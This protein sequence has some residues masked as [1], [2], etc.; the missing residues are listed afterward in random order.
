MPSVDVT[1]SWEQTV[2]RIMAEADKPIIENQT[3]EN[4]V[5][6]SGGLT[7]NLTVGSGQVEISRSSKR[8][9]KSHKSQSRP[10]RRRDRRRDRI[11]EEDERD[12]YA[13]TTGTEEVD[14]DLSTVNVTSGEN[15]VEGQ[16]VA[17]PSILDQ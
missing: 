4:R 11:E 12:D 10:R 6:V 16:S 15:V 3:T 2:S 8:R 5:D 14:D 1:L 17:S 9:S 13:T 7:I